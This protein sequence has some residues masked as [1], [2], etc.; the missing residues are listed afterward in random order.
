MAETRDERPGH[1]A[2]A[3]LVEFIDW[4]G[5]DHVDKRGRVEPMALKSLKGYSPLIQV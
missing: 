3:F 4:V 2:N 1:A 5:D